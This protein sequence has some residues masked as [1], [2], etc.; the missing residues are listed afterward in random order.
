VV[1]ATSNR[2]RL[3]NQAAD[4]LTFDGKPAIDRWRFAKLR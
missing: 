4:D 1:I 2:W 3:L